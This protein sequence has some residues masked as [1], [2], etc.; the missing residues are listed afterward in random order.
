VVKRGIFEGMTGLRW[1]PWLGRR[2]APDRELE[3]SGLERP[4]G[5]N[6]ARDLVNFARHQAR[7]TFGLKFLERC[8]TF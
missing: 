5:S 6:A 8:F 1:R 2:C 4:A 3:R 7:L